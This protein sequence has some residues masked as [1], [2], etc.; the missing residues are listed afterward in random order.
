M[1]KNEKKVQ[2]VTLTT[3]IAESLGD[4][5]KWPLLIPE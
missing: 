4:V 1:H 5:P 3:D 2:N